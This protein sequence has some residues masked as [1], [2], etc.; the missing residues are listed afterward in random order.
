MKWSYQSVVSITESPPSL[1]ALLL[2]ATKLLHDGY[3]S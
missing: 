3:I 2:D 1:N